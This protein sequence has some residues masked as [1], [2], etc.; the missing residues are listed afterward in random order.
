[1]PPP[2]QKKKKNKVIEKQCSFILKI[3]VFCL[4]QVYEF[5]TGITTDTLQNRREC[6]KWCNILIFVLK[7]KTYNRKLLQEIIQTVTSG[8]LHVQLTL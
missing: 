4:L 3:I 1:M 6:N 7:G 5:E 2:P 8:K